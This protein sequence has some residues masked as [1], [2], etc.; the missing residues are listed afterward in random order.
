MAEGAA[1]GWAGVPSEEQAR[2]WWERVTAAATSGDGAISAAYD[3]DELV[4]LAQWQRYELAPQAH[5]ADLDKVLVSS[6]C[7]GRGVG[8]ALVEDMLAQARAAGVET[9]TLQCRG[10]NHGAIRLYRRWG[11]AEFGRLPDF[12]G[13]GDERWDKVLMAVDL[14]TGDEPLVRHGDDP[15]GDGHSL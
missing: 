5:N 7:R 4:G 14:R 2:S 11:F 1:L 6:R 3:G 10:N 9:V 15:V 8:A 13:V 12:V